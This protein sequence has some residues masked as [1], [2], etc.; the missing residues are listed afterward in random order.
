MCSVPTEVSAAE[1]ARWLA[2]LAEALT[3]AHELLHRLSFV[4]RENGLASELYL[5]IEGARLEVQALRLSRSLNG[6]QETCP[7][8]TEADPWRDVGPL[9]TP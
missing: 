1:R 2:E 4:E 6:R 8:W 9:Q 7:E 3:D 5:R